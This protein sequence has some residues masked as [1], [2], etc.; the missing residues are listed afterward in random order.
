MYYYYLGAT[1]Q[2]LVAC[3]RTYRRTSLYLVLQHKTNPS[4]LLF[5]V[6]LLLQ[7]LVAL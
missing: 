5:T 6:L 7:V 3:G 1:P 4:S 2:E